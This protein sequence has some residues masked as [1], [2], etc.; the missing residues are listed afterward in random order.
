MPKIPFQTS[1]KSIW[2]PSISV[3]KFRP[4]SPKNDD[5]R[6]LDLFLGAK[7]IDWR[8]F[9]KKKLT[10][11]ILQKILTGGILQKF[12]KNVNFWT[13]QASGGKKWPK[14]FF[15]KIPSVIFFCKIP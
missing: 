14:N 15:C 6:R 11:G 1:P 8:N 3:E 2:D 9:T 5:F 4:K 7:K 12:W 10:D 13:L